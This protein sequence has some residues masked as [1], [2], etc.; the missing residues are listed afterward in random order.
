MKSKDVK[1]SYHAYKKDEIKE[2]HPQKQQIFY[3]MCIVL[4]V[5]KICICNFDTSG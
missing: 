1:S 4:Y 5:Y 3:Y 2:T